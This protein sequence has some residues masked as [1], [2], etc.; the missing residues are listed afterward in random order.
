MS[1]TVDILART[2]WG[3]ARGEGKEG[4]E[5]VACVV[6]NRAS[7]PRWWGVDIISVC[8]KP[9]Q[10]SCWNV[11]DPNREKLLAVTGADPV[12]TTALAVADAA[13]NGQLV[14]VTQ[15]ADS[16]YAKTSPL[17]DWAASLS[18][19][20]SVGNHVFYKTEL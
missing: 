3:E 13:V 10:F 18:P 4:M 7:H 8:Q 12:F 1:D 20:A 9:W 5:A 14:D 19:V 17:P 2:I 11:S 6:L 16:Y 15:G